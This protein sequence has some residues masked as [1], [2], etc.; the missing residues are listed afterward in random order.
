[1]AVR[2]FG[3]LLGRLLVESVLCGT[4]EC[5]HRG[6]MEQYEASALHTICAQGL[7]LT[8]SPI[9]QHGCLRRFNSKGKEA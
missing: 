2:W 5:L 3:H 8:S 1:M 6:L 7:P 9:N 4:S